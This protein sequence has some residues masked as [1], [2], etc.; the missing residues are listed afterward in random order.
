MRV[1]SA[2]DGYTY[3]LRTVAAAGR[4]QIVFYARARADLI[5]DGTLTPGPEVEL[6]DGTM[7]GAGDTII[8]RRN[9]RRLRNG[10]EWVR[11]GDTWPFRTS[12][13]TARSPS[14]GLDAASAERSCSRLPTWPSTLTSATQ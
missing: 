6:A 14:A 13:T 5:L 10:K 7:A 3:L 2:G 1:M 4:R 9:D 11:N 12:A 8:T